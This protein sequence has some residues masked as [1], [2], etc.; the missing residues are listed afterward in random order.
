MYLIVISSKASDSWIM[1]L[2]LS[3][4]EKYQRLLIVSNIYTMVLNIKLYPDNHNTSQ[5]GSL[6]EVG[7]DFIGLHIYEA[8]AVILT[9]FPFFFE[10]SRKLQ[11]N[12]WKPRWFQREGENGPY[13]YAGGYW[14]AREQGRW[15]G[16]PSI[17]GEFNEDVHNPENSWCELRFVH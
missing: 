7:T 9:Y 15:D 10:Q 4:M 2:V 6:Y 8:F 14:E 5:Q 13:Y 1:S 11:E 17:F 16:C 3:L 12:G